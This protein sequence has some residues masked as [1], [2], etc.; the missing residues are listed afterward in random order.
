MTK[1]VDSDLSHCQ[2]VTDMKRL[3]DAC[4]TSDTFDLKWTTPIL[5][6]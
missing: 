5:I 6:S 4:A 2:N 1:T 3:L